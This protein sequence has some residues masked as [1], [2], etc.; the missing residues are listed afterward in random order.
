MKRPPREAHGGLYR[1]KVA[2]P[3]RFELPTTWFVARYSIQLSYGRVVF[4]GGDPTTTPFRPANKDNPKKNRYLGATSDSRQAVR[5]G[6]QAGTTTWEF[7]LDAR[8][9]RLRHGQPP[10]PL[11]A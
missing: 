5:D 1:F 11:P 7:T 4:K 2:R 9:E 8:H 6:T 10:L 3:E